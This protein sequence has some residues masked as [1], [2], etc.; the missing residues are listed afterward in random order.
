MPFNPANASPGVYV[1]EQSSGVHTITG[2]ATSITA[3]VGL[4]ETGPDNV[5]T[6]ILSFTDYQNTFGS[7]VSYSQVSYAV[8]Q[9]FLNGGNEAYVIRLIGQNTQG[10]T[11]TLKQGITPILQIDSL[12]KG[13]VDRVTEVFVIDEQQ[14]NPTSIT[15]IVVDSPPS[16]QSGPP[17]DPASVVTEVFTGLTMLNIENQ[18]N[19]PSKLIHVTK[20]LPAGGTT[21][22]DAVGPAHGTWTGGALTSPVTTPSGKTLRIILDNGTPYTITPTFTPTGNG[23]TLQASDIATGIQT[24]VT[25]LQPANPSFKNFTCTAA[26]NGA[27]VLSSGSYGLISSVKVQTASGDTLADELKLSSSTGGIFAKAQGTTLNPGTSGDFVGGEEYNLFIADPGKGIY[28]LDTVDLFNILCLPGITDATILNPAN[29]YCQRRRAILLADPPQGNN[30]TTMYTE[31]QDNAAFPFA[32]YAAIYY[33]WVQI[34]DPANKGTVT[35][36]PPSGTIAGLFARIDSTRGVWKAPAGTEATLAGVVALETKLTDAQNG[37]LNS[38]AVNCLRILP[39]YGVVCW[40]ARTRA[41][42]DNAGSEYN[43][44]P[45]RRTALYIEESLYRGLKW[46]VFEPNDYPL[47]AQIRL[48]VGSFMNDLFRKGAFQGQ[49]P[50]DAYFVKCDSETTTQ[51]DINNGVVNIV[52]GFAPLKPAEFVVVTVQQMAGQL[53]V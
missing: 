6:Q 1:F 19:G 42:S 5:A 13:K 53:Q 35:S 34:A 24:A 28:A 43:Y 52:V 38:S 7:L 46:A 31:A 26:S 29:V 33:P 11:I 45:V 25:A 3:F 36:F 23:K 21:L 4:T 32:E 49:T 15:L 20:L 9:F 17:L 44:V 12:N 50:R 10:A 16:N 47:W 41:G 14:Q 18:I 27:Q 39:V 37:V 51:N 48:N 30:P 40:G 22:P 2:V 8:N